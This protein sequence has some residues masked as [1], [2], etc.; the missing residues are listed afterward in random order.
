MGT[1]IQRLLH[2]NGSP[3]ITDQEIPDIFKQT[4][5]G[6]YRTDK[7]SS[8]TFHPRTNMRM[9]T[10]HI[11][12]SETQRALEA[13]NPNKGAGP[14]GPISKALKTLSPYIALTLSRI[15]NLLLLLTSQIP[16]D[17]RH[18]IVTPVAKAPRTSDP[19]LFRPMKLTCVV[20][21]VLETIL[22]ENVLAHLPQFALLT[23]RQHGFLHRRSTLTNLLMA[24]ELLTKWLDE[25]CAV[26]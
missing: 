6:F 14:D 4:F 20:C 9:E 8:P 19:N 5:Q 1:R 7:E 3:A 23:L 16:D 22:K 11:T 18:A 2:P 24:E 10:P 21:K 12:E 26:D 13:L 17:W 15:F 25:G